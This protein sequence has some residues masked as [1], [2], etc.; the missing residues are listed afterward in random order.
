MKKKIRHTCCFSHY[1]WL[2]KCWNLVHSF[3]KIL[4]TMS[5]PVNPLNSVMHIYI[6]F[7]GNIPLCILASVLLKLECGERLRILQKSMTYS[8]DSCCS[9]HKTT[10]FYFAGVWDFYLTFFLSNETLWITE[11]RSNKVWITRVSNLFFICKKKNALSEER[12]R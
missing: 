4:Y 10:L 8:I 7:I 5:N 2:C 12:I 6:G 3:K 1:Y 11:G 9:K